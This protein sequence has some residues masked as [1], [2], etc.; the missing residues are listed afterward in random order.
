MTAS[1][2]SARRFYLLKRQVAERAR[3]DMDLVWRAK[4]EAQLGTDL[5][6]DFPHRS[7]LVERGY[8]TNEDLDGADVRELQAQ[9]FSRDDAQTILAAV[10]ED[11]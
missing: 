5:A 8:S 4:Q 10:S 7:A 9:G 2:K 1:I 11:A 3:D 6:E